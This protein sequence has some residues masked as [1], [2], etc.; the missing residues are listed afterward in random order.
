MKYQFIQFEKEAARILEDSKNIAAKIINEAKIEAQAE[1]QRAYHLGRQEGI[2]QGIKDG[3]AQSCAIIDELRNIIN[4]IGQ[5]VETAKSTY[6]RNFQ[7]ELAEI[8]LEIIEKILEKEAVINADIAKAN[9][10]KAITLISKGSGLQI[11][12]NPHDYNRLESFLAGLKHSSPGIIINQ[13]DSIP[14]GGCIAR[15]RKGIIDA[16]IKSQIEKLKD[17][18]LAG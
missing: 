14:I 18:I 3:L 8:V 15:T 16:T 10:T 4:R 9:I 7:N 17:A 6:L 13:D 11:Q 2:Q 12:I 5:T 1:K